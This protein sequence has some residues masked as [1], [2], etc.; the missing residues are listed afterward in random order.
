MFVCGPT[1]YDLCHIGHARTYIVFDVIARYLRFRGH[2]LFFLMNI[3][4]IA[5]KVIGRSRE[6]GVGFMELSRRY[7]GYFLEDL[8][9]LGIDSVD[10]FARA[11]D[12][13]PEII[14]QV[15]GLLEKGFAYETRTGVYFSIDKSP[16]YG[17]L[18]KQARW[19]ISLRPIELCS[20]KRRPEDFSLWRRT[21][22]EPS[23]DSPW[24]PGR[25]GWHVEDT[26]IAMK[27]LG[28]Q[29]DLHGG[30]AEL[31]F[32]HH[33]AEIAQGEALSGRKP[34]VRFW[35]HAGLV[36]VGGRKMGKSLGNAIPI[37][38][39]LKSHGHRELRFYLLSNHY[40]RP[41]DFSPSELERSK[42]ELQSIEKAIRD[43]E[44]LPAAGGSTRCRKLI[45][46]L[47]GLEALFMESMDDDF[48]TPKA[49]EAIRGMANRL[50]GYARRGKGVDESTRRRALEKVNGLARVLGI[51]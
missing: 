27:F 50:D 25:P 26:A 33:E 29:Y 12:H 43:F 40:R 38:E 17:A 9:S 32:P 19:E 14:E 47:E 36:R 16:G 37:R 11:S 7:E 6:V 28:P 8:R 31:I 24:G 41:I 35:L 51:L 30:A 15:K 5:E 42:E 2:R 39:I 13:I 46:D 10:A 23:W 21:D 34:Y 20:T 3:T 1:V 49:L 45:A 4:D 48:N 22:G 44:D 18:S